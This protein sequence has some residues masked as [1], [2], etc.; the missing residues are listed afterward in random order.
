MDLAVFGVIRDIFGGLVDLKSENLIAQSD[1]G[2]SFEGVRNLIDY[3]SR[4]SVP[5][6]SDNESFR[7]VISS[8]AV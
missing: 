4:F 2:P 8:I 7:I 5:P 6:G 3:L 1:N